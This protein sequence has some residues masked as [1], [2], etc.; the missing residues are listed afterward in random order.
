[1]WRYKLQSPLSK[2]LTPIVREYFEIC[3]F[4][5]RPQDLPAASSLLWISV[6]FYT[7]MSAVMAY[8]SQTIINAVAS[9]FT[10]TII[11]LT[12]TYLFLY[13][14]SV[15]QRWLQ[16]CS[17]LA[18]TGIIFSLIVIP[19]YYL[20]FYGSIGP[21]PQ[22]LILSLIMLIWFWN[23]AVMSHILKNA[24]SSSYLLATTATLC[25]IAIIMMTLQQLFPLS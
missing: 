15:P 25:Y 8:P 23:I 13:L 5:K 2:Y 9:G 19:L 11:L 7:L 10:E 6:V 22:G 4:R 12:I 18:G 16:V 24:L 17:A 20:R 1:M 14:R 21:S 3:L